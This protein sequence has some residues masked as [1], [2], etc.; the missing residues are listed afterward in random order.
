MKR[1]FKETY[2]VIGVNLRPLLVFELLYRLAAGAL[3]I[4]ITSL[5]SASPCGRRALVI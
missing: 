5:C 2:Q 1:Y 3:Y 4:R